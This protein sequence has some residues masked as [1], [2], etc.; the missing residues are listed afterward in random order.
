MYQ[1]TFSPAAYRQLEDLP[2]PDQ[3]RIRERIDRLSTNPRPLF[4][5]KQK[6]PIFAL[7]N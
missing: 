2:K 5:A 4:G 7:S 1:I 6:V 3:R